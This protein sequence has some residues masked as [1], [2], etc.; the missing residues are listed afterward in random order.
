MHAW[1]LDSLSLRYD[2]MR[3]ISA[4]TAFESILHAYHGKGGLI[5]PK[6]FL[7]SSMK[8]LQM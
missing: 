4:S 1:Y 3:F 5:I 2:V 7:K 6:M 8:E